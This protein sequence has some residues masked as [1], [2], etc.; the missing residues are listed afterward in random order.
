MK[1]QTAQEASPPYLIF[2]EIDYEDNLSISFTEDMEYPNGIEYFRADN[3]GA[4]YFWLSYEPSESTDD[5]IYNREVNQTN[6]M[7]WS[8]LD[9][10]PN[11]IKFNIEFT[12][13]TAVSTSQLDP[14]RIIFSLIR[15][16]VLIGKTSQK[17]IEILGQGSDTYQTFSTVAFLNGES[18]RSRGHE[19]QIATY[20][21][22]L[23]VTI[24]SVMVGNTVITLFLSGV[25]QYLT[26]LI[27]AAQMMVFTVL[28]TISTP[29]NAKVI[30]V[31]V[32][33]L[34]AFDF[35]YTEE[36]Y[37]EVLGLGPGKS[38]SLIFDE[39]EIEGSNF[40]VG[41]GSVFIYAVFFP[42]WII[43]HQIS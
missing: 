28:F 22:S 40:I 23:E 6:T 30:F 39:A 5:F 34:C 18:R 24:Q 15:P 20:K 2:E 29:N 4:E 41:I 19:E 37:Y 36:L 35:F 38:F 43:V 31:T 17:P 25:F 9:V 42:I 16:D 32:L 3:L 11:G 26:G 7:T 13:P 21:A 10:K 14:D 33:K 27:Y 12:D 1:K 8:V